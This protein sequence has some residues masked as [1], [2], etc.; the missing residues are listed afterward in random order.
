LENILELMIFSMY[1]L[2]SFLEGGKGGKKRSNIFLD[3]MKFTVILLANL[4]SSACVYILKIC[5]PLV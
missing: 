4:F 2:I 5:K 3:L 1:V